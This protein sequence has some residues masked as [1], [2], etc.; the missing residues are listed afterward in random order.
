MLQYN[1]HYYQS[2]LLLIVLV[3]GRVLPLSSVKVL[4]PV[5]VHQPCRRQ[6]WYR[7]EHRVEEPAEDI[8]DALADD[9]GKGFLLKRREGVGD[10]VSG[11]DAQ[12]TKVPPHGCCSEHFSLFPLQMKQNKGSNKST[13]LSN[14]LIT[15]L[16]IT[17]LA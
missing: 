17:L 5:V 10:D 11:T 16:S 15:T 4:G 14:A 6:T 2:S 13:N 3:D 9:P 8:G 1:I 12:A 7:V